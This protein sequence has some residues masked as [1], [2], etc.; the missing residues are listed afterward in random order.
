MSNNTV[1][2]RNSETGE[3]G[4]V[5]RRIFESSVFNPQGLLLI[6]VA[7]TRSGC[8]GCGIAP[9]DCPAEECESAEIELPEIEI[10]EED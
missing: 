2:V 4:E 9:M 5:R 3:V 1:I 6:E 10:E 7:D 8:E